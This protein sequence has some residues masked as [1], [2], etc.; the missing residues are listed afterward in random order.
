MRVP[1]P[2]AGI[3]AKIAKVVLLQADIIAHGLENRCP[4]PIFAALAS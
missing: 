3:R 4:T 2:A 1:L